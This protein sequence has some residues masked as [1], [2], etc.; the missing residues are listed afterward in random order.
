MTTKIPSF[1]LRAN[2]DKILTEKDIMGKKTL[3][4]FY[5]KDD[6]PGCSVQANDF[7][8]LLEDFKQLAIQI[9]GVSPDNVESHDQFI[10]KNNIGFS[11]ISDTEKQL[12]NFFG[13][14]G[15]KKNY[16]KTYIGLI[17]STFLIDKKGYIIK[18]WRN[19]R[20]K[21]H[22]ARILKEVQALLVSN[23]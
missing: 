9:I 22:A 8:E 17:R 23:P 10:E 5:P 13:V 19:V 4:Y 6:T 20:A 14:W 16:G 3:L 2:N 21:G 1:E 18:E 7:T 12:A 11:L 15:E